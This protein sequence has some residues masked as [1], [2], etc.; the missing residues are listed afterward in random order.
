MITD[1][2]VWFG[3]CDLLIL[4]GAKI[5]LITFVVLLNY[6][7][8]I[9]WQTYIT[10]YPWICTFLPR[11]KKIFDKSVKST[12]IYCNTFHFFSYLFANKK[13]WSSIWNSCL[14]YGTCKKR[15]FCTAAASSAISYL[16]QLK[17]LRPPPHP[18]PTLLMLTDNTL[19]DDSFATV[20]AFTDLI[21]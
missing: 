17:N 1:Q 21:L 5:T 13:F 4:C 2:S 14:Q 12:F 19:N 18:H 15:T 6:Q 8:Y 11:T 9:N 10:G 20:F 7:G 16:Q 3:F